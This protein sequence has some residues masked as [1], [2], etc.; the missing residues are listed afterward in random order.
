MLKENERSDS[1]P[2]IIYINNSLHR[3]IVEPKHTYI[4]CVYTILYF[5]MP[6]YIHNTFI[7]QTM[8]IRIHATYTNG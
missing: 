7:K 6:T 4:L 5:V 3:K 2:P 1:G 8:H